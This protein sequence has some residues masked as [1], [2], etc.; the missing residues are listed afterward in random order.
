MTAPTLTT[1]PTAPSKEDP[2]DVFDG[3]ADPFLAWMEL[4]GNTELPAV[5]AW[6]DSL[7]AQQSAALAAAVNTINSTKTSSVGAVNSAKASA[8]AA[9]DSA[10][11]A[12]AASA[13]ATVNNMTIGVNVTMTANG[14]YTIPS[15]LPVDHKL[16]LNVAGNLK[17]NPFT[18]NMNGYKFQGG[19]FTSVNWDRNV[20]A[21]LVLVNSTYGFGIR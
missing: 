12:A 13:V 19:A 7:P 21:E 3:K 2:E 6:M 4:L 11:T 15:G 5:I 16:N 14:S 8:L 20:G 10:I 9:I 17:E 18:L 1:A